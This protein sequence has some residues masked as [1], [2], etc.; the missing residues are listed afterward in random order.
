[1]N[2]FKKFHA[3]LSN[4]SSSTSDLDI[5]ITDSLNIHSNILKFTSDKLN[6]SLELVFEKAVV[7]NDATAVN[8]SKLKGHN[9]A[10][11][12]MRYS[13]PSILLQIY[14]NPCLYWL[15]RPAFFVLLQKINTP[16]EE[17]ASEMEI[18]KNIFSSEFV[19]S[20]CRSGNQDLQPIFEIMNSINV[21]EKQELSD[22]LLTAILPFIFCYF[23]VVEVIKNQVGLQTY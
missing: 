15:H 18:M 3:L 5:Y 20:K 9:L 23:N 10:A 16:I 17:I 2:F 13:F 22:L 8:L 6:A 21:M 4:E 11:H 1:M 19:T 7:T 12:T 14:C